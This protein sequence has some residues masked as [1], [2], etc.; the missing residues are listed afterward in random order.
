MSSQELNDL[1]QIPERKRIVFLGDSITE[2][3]G[4]I[5]YLDAFFLKHFPGH[6]MELINLGVGSETAAGTHESSHPFPRP[7]VH[8]RLGRALE[9]C[10]PDWVFLCYGMND[11]IYHSFSE[12]RFKLFQD[13][14]KNAVGQVKQTGARVILMTP[15]P[16]DVHSINGEAQ[17]EGLSEYAF[18]TPYEDYNGVLG[19]YADWV[20]GYGAEQGYTVVNLREPLMFFIAMRR[21]ADPAYKYND[22]V[23]PED[24]GHWI[25]AR[26][27]LNDVFQIEAEDTP[28][29]ARSMDGS[30]IR[31]VGRRR[32]VL[33]A[34]WREHVGHSNPQKFETLPLADALKLADSL[35]EDIRKLAGQEDGDVSAIESL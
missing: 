25:M 8:E 32:D 31:A 14:M 24:D 29:W 11:G 19:R 33:N 1:L 12:E 2:N 13:G 9:E 28:E 20:T 26:A 34:A 22:G 35:L 21:E 3:G 4:Y 17:P 27:I 23:H 6:N 18:E 30:F 15:P 7:C 16:F 10:K 5:R